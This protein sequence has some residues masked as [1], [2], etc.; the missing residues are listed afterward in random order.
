MN[1]LSCRLLFLLVASFFFAGC[2]GV[3]LG[4]VTATLI[5]FKPTQATLL[6]STGT[7]TIR[8]TNEN[9]SPLGFSGSS[10]KLYLNGSY[11]GKAVSDQ[12]FGIPPLNTVTQDVT[13]H[14][15]NLSLVRQLLAVRETQTAAYR[16][17]SVIFQTVYEEEYEYKTRS[18]GSLDLRGVSEAIGGKQ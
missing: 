18:E 12:P 16:L 5:D 1:S 2:S 15:E 17:E 4:G 9:I 3:K 7:L 14:F 13:I 11:V 8:Y 6:E 10:H